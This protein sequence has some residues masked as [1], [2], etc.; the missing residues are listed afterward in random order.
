MRMD[1]IEST[2]SRPALPRRLHATRPHRPV[3]TPVRTPRHGASCRG[4]RGAEQGRNRNS[5]P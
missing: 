3:G 1:R 4:H 2:S 5:G